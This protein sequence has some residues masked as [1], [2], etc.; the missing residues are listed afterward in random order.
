MLPACEA[1]SNLRYS[2]R[3][4]HSTTGLERETIDWGQVPYRKAWE[5]Q[6]ERVAARQNN[7]AADALIFT[8]HPPVFTI[9]VRRGAEAHLVWPDAQRAAFGVDLVH[10]NRGGDIT[11]HGPGQIVGYPIVSLQ[12]YRDLHGYLR[13]IEQTIINTVGCLGLA[14]ARRPGK[15][16]IWLG[17]R[18]I[19]AIGIAVR[20]WVS[21]HGFALNLSNDL[22]PF[23]GIVPCGI[24][25][26]EVTSVQRELGIVFDP[27]EVKS[28]LAA[29]FW[30]LFAETFP[31]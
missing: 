7:T 22:T 28:I 10:T 14:A 16:G 21:F 12:H 4:S 9:G 30:K 29:E 3:L 11:Y 13:L 5:R 26:G 23:S 18:K 25:D 6:L 17:N 8:E 1:G 24:A 15:T 27:A 2:D 31:S 20:R 19:A